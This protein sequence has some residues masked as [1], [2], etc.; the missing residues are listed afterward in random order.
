MGEYYPDGTAKI[1][2][3]NEV[4]PRTWE[5]RG[6]DQVCFLS[7]TETDCFFLELNRSN[8]GKFR[9]A[10]SKRERSPSSD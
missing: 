7:E 9:S 6:G 4:F 5:V 8:P 2:A 3:W 10:A 1:E